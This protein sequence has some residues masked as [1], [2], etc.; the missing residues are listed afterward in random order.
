MFAMFMHKNKSKQDI[1]S[2]VAKYQQI[3]D[4]GKLKDYNEAKTVNEFIMPIFQFLCWDIHN[5]HAD[6][7]TPEETCTFR[8]DGIPK[9]FLEAIKAFN[10]DVP[11]K[12]L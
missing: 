3:A 5:L 10:A 12:N 7:V 9:F 1:S 6:E 8:I 11:T 4:T 2:L